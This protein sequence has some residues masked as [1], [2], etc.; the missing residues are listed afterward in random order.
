MNEITLMMPPG[1]SGPGS[2]EF[3]MLH[4]GIWHRLPSNPQ[5]SSLNRDSIETTLRNQMELLAAAGPGQVMQVIRNSISRLLFRHLL[6][7][8]LQDTLSEA[9]QQG[10]GSAPTLRIHTAGDWIPWEL[11]HD[12]ADFLGVHFVIARLPIKGDKH[13][14]ASDEDSLAPRPVRS[15]CSL[16]GR[17]VLTEANQFNQ[18]KTTFAN[19]A[20][21]P[22]QEFRRPS[23]REDG[24]DSPSLGTL[25]QNP[26]P[27]S[28]LHF[29]CHGDLQNQAGEIYWTLDHRS[30][31]PQ[32]YQI[33]SWSIE[34]MSDTLD[35]RTNRPLVFG[36]ACASAPGSGRMLAGLGMTF[37]E[38]GAS[39]FVGTFAPVTKRIA[40][41]FAARFY[42]RLLGDGLPIG[43]AL[44]ATKQAY[45]DEGESDPSWLFYCLY[46]PPE[47]R[48]QL[49]PAL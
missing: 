17:Q 44:R 48:Y 30:E 31:N 34:S 21:Q 38:Y 27:P 23:E 14:P 18:W 46:G 22:V 3:W 28:I 32:A 6:P 26:S 19:V 4:R 49:Q 39:A 7:S 29:T 37:F 1:N 42:A 25:E 35:F 8:Q 15:V 20:V 47:T 41:G 9:M 36:N 5:A 13:P 33:D 45:L 2:P 40:V 10:H 43:E 12:G 24:P 11:L 16:L